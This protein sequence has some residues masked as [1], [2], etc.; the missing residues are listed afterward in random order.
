MWKRLFSKVFRIGCGQEQRVGVMVL[1]GV[2]MMPS[3][4]VAATDDV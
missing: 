1:I 2:A 3:E 4:P